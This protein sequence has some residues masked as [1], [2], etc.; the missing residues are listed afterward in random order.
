MEKEQTLDEWTPLLLHLNY[1][2]WWFKIGIPDAFQVLS[3]TG[4]NQ[5]VNSSAAPK[6]IASRSVTCREFLRHGPRSQWE[7][8]GFEKNGRDKKQ[9]M[10]KL[11]VKNN[12][13]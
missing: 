13:R 5:L 1:E 8:W 12:R 9:G 10:P 3:L 11:T 6:V 7:R 4:A 2:L